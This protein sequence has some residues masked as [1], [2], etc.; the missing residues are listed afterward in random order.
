MFNTT[1]EDVGASQAI[2]VPA[3]PELRNGYRTA[4]FF[5]RCIKDQFPVR[6]PDDLARFCLS[7]PAKA[8]HNNGG[9]KHVG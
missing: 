4:R 7:E 6:L 5:W 1:R 2:L 9:G 8:E 3:L